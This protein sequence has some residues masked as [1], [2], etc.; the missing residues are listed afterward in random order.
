MSLIDPPSAV[1]IL[2]LQSPS[3]ANVIDL[4]IGNDARSMI[5]ILGGTSSIHLVL[6]GQAAMARSVNART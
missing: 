4:N 2:L 6:R 5:I 3:N 1:I